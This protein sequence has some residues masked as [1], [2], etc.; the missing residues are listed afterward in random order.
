M[1]REGKETCENSLTE[2]KQSPLYIALK[3]SEGGQEAYEMKHES[4]DLRNDL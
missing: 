2:L 3:S 4:F 1:A